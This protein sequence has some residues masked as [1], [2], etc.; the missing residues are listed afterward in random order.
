MISKREKIRKRLLDAISDKAELNYIKGPVE[1]TKFFLSKK[2]RKNY[3]RRESRMHSKG[4]LDWLR[5]H[6]LLPQVYWDDWSDLRDGFRNDWLMIEKFR[7]KLKDRH[8][9][10]IERKRQVKKFHENKLFWRDFDK[11]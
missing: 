4:N 6:C 8:L 7:D 10:K 11:Y 2:D 3:G 1:H 9:P 5:D